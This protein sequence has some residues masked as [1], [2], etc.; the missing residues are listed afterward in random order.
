MADQLQERLAELESERARLRDAFARFGD[1]LSATHDPEQLLQVV[2][3]ATAEATGAAGATLVDERGTIRTVGDVDSG[4][5]RLELPLNAG[6]SSFGTLVLVGWEFGDEERLTASSLAAHA[7]VALENARLHSI[8]EEQALVDS[9]TTLA[10]RRH[11]EETLVAELAR[12]ERFGSSLTAIFADLDDFKRVNDEYGHPAGDLVL[13]EFAAVLRENVREADVAGR[14]GGEEFLLLLPGTDAPGGALLAERIRAT[15]AERVIL[16]PDGVP[17]R[18]TVSLG[19][20]TYPACADAAALLESADA[21]LYSA[22]RSGK[23]R[24]VAAEAAARHP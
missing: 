10:N 5:E 4:G 21:A 16:T 11:C 1:A 9:L 12:A 2:L 20:A 17:I 7:V 19:V 24:V 3:E 15:L 13:R 6:R 23:N 14:W 22:K 8:V 18:L